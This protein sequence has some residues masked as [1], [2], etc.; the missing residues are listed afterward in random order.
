M[1][2]ILDLTTTDNI[3]FCGKGNGERFAKTV[4]GEGYLLIQVHDDQLISSSFMFGLLLSNRFQGISIT[5]NKFRDT[6]LSEIKRAT[7]RYSKR[8]EIIKS[9]I[10]AQILNLKGKTMKLEDDYLQRADQLLKTF[11]YE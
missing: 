8:E 10:V 9:S 6:H 7:E 1:K 3:L 5:D 4:E 2:A 11:P